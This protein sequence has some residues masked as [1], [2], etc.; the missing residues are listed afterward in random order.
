MERTSEGYHGKIGQLYWFCNSYLAIWSLALCIFTCTAM[1]THTRAVRLKFNKH[2][3]A[4]VCYSFLPHIAQLG[5]I[6][7]YS[8]TTMGSWIHSGEA[9]TTE[10]IGNPERSHSPHSICLY[11]IYGPN[12]YYTSEVYYS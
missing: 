9:N 4:A 11:Q 10:A 7:T 1:A 5:T 3:A 8:F 2:P 12:C 6:S